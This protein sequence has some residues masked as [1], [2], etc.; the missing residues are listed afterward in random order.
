MHVSPGQKEIKCSPRNIGGKQWLQMNIFEIRW[1]FRPMLKIAGDSPIYMNVESTND[2]NLDCEFC[3]YRSH[4]K[5]YLGYMRMDTFKRIVDECVDIGVYELKL[6]WRGEPLLHPEISKFVSYAKDAG[7]RFVSLNT[8][9]ILLTGSISEDLLSSRIDEI[10]LS[11]D[12][13]H[14]C[15]YET[16]FLKSYSNVI[17]NIENL[18]RLKKRKENKVII[19]L[20]YVTNGQVG[21][22][23]EANKLF[24]YMDR[25][26][27]VK[28]N[29]LRIQK[30]V[31][32][33]KS[34]SYPF[35]RLLCSWDG[36]FAVCCMD[37][38]FQFSLNNSTQSSILNVWNGRR[39]R[40]LREHHRRLQFP[41]EELCA[42]C[43]LGNGG[44]SQNTE[45]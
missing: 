21:W 25:V 11:V 10:L 34:C 39:M 44:S 30:N 45:W 2:C 36:R 4:M 27:K 3:G 7:I 29:I 9:G 24:P 37:F 26:I 13:M 32:R 41:A 28:Q 35:V 6:D 43:N 14:K 40:T 33:K 20:Q 12:H 19:G 5:D 1:R 17:R 18:I 22:V 38:N 31:V 23:K 8:N 42:N 15:A 16:K